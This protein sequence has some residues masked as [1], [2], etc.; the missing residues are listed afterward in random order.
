MSKIF[1]NIVTD[2]SYIQ[3]CGPISQVLADGW[4]DAIFDQNLIGNSPIESEL[5]SLPRPLNTDLSNPES[6]A[7]PVTPPMFTSPNFNHPLSTRDQE[8]DFEHYG[9]LVEEEDICVHQRDC[10]CYNS[11]TNAGAE[12]FHMIDLD[13][14]EIES[15]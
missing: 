14:V 7:L 10:N 11:R 9:S 15:H 5:P 1:N 12:L 4:T 3:V 13:I 8:D 6:I 2:T